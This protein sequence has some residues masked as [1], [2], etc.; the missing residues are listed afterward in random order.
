LQIPELRPSLKILHFNLIIV[1]TDDAS[2]T[3]TIFVDFTPLWR[4]IPILTYVICITV[5]HNKFVIASSV[6][7]FTDEANKFTDDANI[8]LFTGLP[9]SASRVAQSV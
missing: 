9:M 7:S 8:F 1:F 2:L 6:K 4:N 3:I 5:N